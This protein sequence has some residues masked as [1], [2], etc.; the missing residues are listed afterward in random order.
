MLAARFKEAGKPLSI[1]DIA[2]PSIG[3]EEVLVEIEAAGICGSDVHYKR[4][5]SSPS[6]VPLTLGHEGAGIV[7]EV[8]NNVTNVKAGDNVII[9]YVISCG[10]CKSCLQGFDNR[11]RNRISIGH[12]VDGT[13]AEFIKIPAR[14]AM[15]VAKHVPI[16][17]GAI[18]ACAVSTAYHAVNRSGLKSGDTAVIFGVGGVG[19]HAVMWAKFFGAEKVIAVDLVD[20]KLEVAKSY[21]ADLTINP[22]RDD[23]LGTIARETDGWGADVSIEC[24][25]SPKAMEQAIKA[26]KGKNR[27][28]SGTVVSVGLQTKPFQV[29]YWN[30]RE[31]WI[32]VSGDH[33][34]FDLYQIIK[35]MESGRID[36]SR[37]IT[38]RISLREINKGIDLVE[39][40]SEHVERVVIDMNMK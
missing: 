4:G 7:R 33:T 10:Y 15:R 39:S 6:K 28:E 21:G 20:S 12:D 37:S 26:I 14:N 23:V 25:G 38:H 13:F 36:L 19:I 31:G 32:T 16:E 22:S 1:E 35:L 11:C 17:W 18:T 9:H 24:S 8:G 5:D 27:V 30:I 3:P 34:R 2:I 29:E 40:R